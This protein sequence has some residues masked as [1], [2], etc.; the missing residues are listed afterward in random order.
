MQND[1]HIELKVLPDDHHTHSRNNKI[2]YTLILVSSVCWVS[3][4]VYAN[5]AGLK[6]WETNLMKGY[7]LA[8][9]CYF[10]CRYNGYPLMFKSK[11]DFQLI[12]LRNVV[13]LVH[14]LVTAAMQYKL[15]L[16]ILHN[17]NSSMSILV[18]IIEVLR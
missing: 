1:N 2:S 3:G 13:F 10:I 8:L 15:P 18:M 6:P 7:P 16:P 12:M 14:G 5:E 11:K 9:V 17:I 4:F